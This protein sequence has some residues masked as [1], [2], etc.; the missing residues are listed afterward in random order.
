MSSKLLNNKNKSI[1]TRLLK[2]EPKFRIV[3][4]VKL[5]NKY[6]VKDMTQNH[7][8]EFHRFLNDTVYKGLMSDFR[9]YA[10]SLSQEEIVNLYSTGL[11]LDNKYSMYTNEYI[12]DTTDTSIYKT[13][14]VVTEEFKE[15]DLLSK[16]KYDKNIYTEPDGSL[17][18]RIFHH[19]NPSS[20][21]FSSS[22]TFSTSVY[23]DENRWFNISF[24]NQLSSWELLVKE[25]ATTSS[26]E[27]RYRWVQN[28]NPMTATYAQVSAANIVKNTSG[29]DTI[30]SSYGG[31]YKNTGSQAYIV[32]NN[33]TQGNWWGATGSWTIFNSGI[34]AYNQVTVTTGYYD[35]Y[36]RIPSTA[37]ITKT[38]KIIGRNFIE[39]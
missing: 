27:V 18:V 8:K 20:G 6:E 21:L 31:L 13:H 19:N 37:G 28:Y 17:W 22:D 10:T 7:V 32:T 35:L 25:K 29:Y 39:R 24:C 12:E 4:E 2:Q 30:N 11:T 38:N 16:L 33:G 14:N 34:P 23:K 5:D 9:L 36:V 1:G 3:F 15:Q 26:N